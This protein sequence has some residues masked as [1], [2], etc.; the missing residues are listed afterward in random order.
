MKLSGHPRFLIVALAF[1]HLTRLPTRGRASGHAHA[2][3]QSGGR[4][5]A[6]DPGGI[7][8]QVGRYTEW[9]AASF[10][11]W[12]PT[13]PEMLIL[14]RF[15]DTNQVHLVTQPG[16]ARTQ[17]TFFPDRVDDASVDP[18]RAPSSFFRKVQA[19]TSSIRITATT[20]RPATSRCSPTE[21]RE[22]PPRP[23]V[24]MG[25]LRLH[26]DPAQRRRQRLYLESPNDP[27][28]DRLL[29]EVKGGGWEVG[30]WS[31][32]DSTFSFSSTSRSTKVISGL[33]TRRRANERS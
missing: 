20:S 5:H 1:S 21:N 13:N 28:S 15:G 22:T 12:H 7:A 18:S 9:R 23:G 30:D 33:S 25:P 4:R 6:T 11:D 26:L 32:D 29:A 31:P 24:T 10:L 2:T 3:R 14:T 27:K 17:L 16:G 8:R 19:G